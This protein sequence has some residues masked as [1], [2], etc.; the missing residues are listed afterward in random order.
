MSTA[1]AAL[2][3]SLF[4]L[5]RIDLGFQPDSVFVARLT[6]PPTSYRTAA[7][8]GRFGT[9]ME[10]ALSRV[11]GVVA[12]GGVSVAPLSGVLRAVPFAP[13]NSPTSAKRDWPAANY[14]AISPGYLRALGGRQ[15][16]G[17]TIE[18]GDNGSAP[19]VVVINRVLAETF[20]PGGSAVGHQILVN[21]TNHEPRALTIVG[22]VE[23]VREIDLDR[24]IEP[25]VFVAVKQVP[26]ESVSFLTATQF[27]AVRVGGKPMLFEPVF[28]KTL[29]D[30][31]R[32]VAAAGSST[33]RRFVDGALAPRRFSVRLMSVFALIALVLTFVGVYGV[34]AYLVEQRRREIGVRMA[35]GAT[36]ARVVGNIVRR[37][38]TLASIGAALG[39]LGAWMTRGLMESQLFGVSANSPSLFAAVVGLMLMTVAAASLVPGLRASR[40]DP[41]VALRGD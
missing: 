22:I 27:W 20:F 34:T 12:A 11:P 38:L 3:R 5:E 30:V 2:A 25:E 8:L 40:V 32:S 35:L 23:N 18:E 31:D 26:Q 33:L 29:R 14:R 13:A 39:M 15:V 24:T 17:R 10:A 1:T 16:A 6:L 9:A 19:A 36:Q 37:S 41:L 4:T 7:E 21:D 28:A